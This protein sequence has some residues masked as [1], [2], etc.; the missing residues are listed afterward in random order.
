MITYLKM[1]L[2]NK[3]EA[4]DSIAFKNIDLADSDFSV[5]LLRATL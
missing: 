4:L 2:L 5:T 3:F 1:V